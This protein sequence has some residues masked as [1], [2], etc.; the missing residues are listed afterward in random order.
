MLK[1]CGKNFTTTHMKDAV[2]WAKDAGIIPSGS[3]IIGLPGETEETVRKS[4]AL[5]QELD[6]YSV[7]FPIAVPF[8]GTILRKMA[9]NHEYGLKILTNNWD[10]YDKQYPGVMESEDLPIEKEESCKKWLIPCCQKRK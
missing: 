6:L 1:R 4:I 5:A 2:R 3:F 7:T 8:P 10:D 9:I